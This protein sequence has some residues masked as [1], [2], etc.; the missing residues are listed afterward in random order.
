MSCG[1][2][3]TLW[4]T[5]ARS[6]AHRLPD[7]K[8]FTALIQRH[9]DERGWT[10]D[11]LARAMA[12]KH[13]LTSKRKIERLLGGG[14]DKRMLVEAISRTLGLNPGERSAAF[15][16]DRM[17]WWR[18]HA[19]LQ[20]SR[21]SPQFWIEASSSWRSPSLMTS[22]LRRTVKVPESLLAESDEATHDHPRDGGFRRRSC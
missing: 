15:R 13:W 20:Q 9:L 14:R 8:A 12:P 17:D 5:F 19:E 4:S 21:F 11:D 2:L 6:S 7:P 3:V 22:G 10:F 16:S 18:H 1:S